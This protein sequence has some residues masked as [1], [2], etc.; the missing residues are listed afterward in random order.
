MPFLNINPTLAPSPNNNIFVPHLSLLKIIILYLSCL[1]IMIPHLFPFMNNNAT[2]VP[3]P[4]NNTP[5]FSTIF[6]IFIRKFVCRKFWILLELT[7][8]QTFYFL[9]MTRLC[10]VDK[11]TW[12]MYTNL[13]DVYC[14]EDMLSSE[15]MKF[16][17]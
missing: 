6:V 15:N 12:P 3:S 4:K 10:W 5:T 8:V 2:P 7:C 1:Q 9:G 13:A 17:K 14:F 16:E 11:H